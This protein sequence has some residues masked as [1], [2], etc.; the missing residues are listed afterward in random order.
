MPAAQ[1]LGLE[2]SIPR[3]QAKTQALQCTLAMMG[4]GG[5]WPIQDVLAPWETLLQKISI[6]ILLEEQ[7]QGWQAFKHMYVY[8]HEHATHSHAHTKEKQQDKETVTEMDGDRH[9]KREPRVRKYR[10]HSSFYRAS[11]ED[12]KWQLVDQKKR[13]QWA[14]WHGELQKRQERLSS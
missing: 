8:I 14:Q 9:K 1:V 3:I 11:V 2:S 5:R 7:H 13:I 6:W 4:R 12:W 10:R